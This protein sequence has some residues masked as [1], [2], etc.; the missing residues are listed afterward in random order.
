MSSL[1]WQILQYLSQKRGREWFGA[2]ER[3]ER[4]YLPQHENVL[5]EGVRIT[6]GRGLEKSIPAAKA[7]PGGS[8]SGL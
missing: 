7:A 4:E 2:R 3:G 8:E 6:R 5:E 1:D